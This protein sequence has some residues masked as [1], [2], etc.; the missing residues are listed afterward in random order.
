MSKPQKATDPIAAIHAEAEKARRSADK[1]G[2]MSTKRAN[3]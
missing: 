2:I 3:A 1:I